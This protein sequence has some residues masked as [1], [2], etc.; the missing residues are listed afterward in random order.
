M[1]NSFTHYGQE[2]ALFDDQNRPTGTPNG[3]GG[4]SKQGKKL[5]LYNSTSVPNKDGSGFTEVANGNGYVTGGKALVEGNF[6]LSIDSGNAQ[7]MIADQTWT[8]AG[9]TVPLI[10]GVYLTDADDNVLAWW[11]R[12]ST[13]TLEDGDSIVAD[14]VFLKL[15]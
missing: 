13:L 1:T 3:D 11:E 2:V 10:A 9:G 6:T 12:G 7:T 8:A 4:I 5:K 14:D 15:T